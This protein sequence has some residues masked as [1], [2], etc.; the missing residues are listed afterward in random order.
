MAHTMLCLYLGVH[1]K[2][3]LGLT[4]CIHTH[5]AHVH[6][7]NHEHHVHGVNDEHHPHTHALTHTHTH[8]HT[9][10]Y[11]HMHFA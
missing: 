8:I 11:T 4:D 3:L 2:F 5:Y 7:V 1:P 6:G 9:H 10:T